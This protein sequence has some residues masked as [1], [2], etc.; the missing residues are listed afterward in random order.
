MGLEGGSVDYFL[1]KKKW[2]IQNQIPFLQG[3]NIHHFGV[4]GGE[5]RMRG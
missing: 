4:A 5:G 2:A 3:L 1:Q